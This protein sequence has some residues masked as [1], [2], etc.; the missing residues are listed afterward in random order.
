M[1]KVSENAPIRSCFTL[2][3]NAG[4]LHTLGGDIY[5]IHPALHAY[6]ERLHPASETL[7]RAFIDFMS[8]IAGQMVPQKI[9]EQRTCFILNS[10]TFYHALHLAKK[11]S[12]EQEAVKLIFS[13]A[14]YAHNSHDYLGAKQL[15]SSLATHYSR[16]NIESNVLHQLGIIAQ[17]Q[18]DFEAAKKLYKQSLEIK[19]KEGNENS[20]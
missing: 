9:H 8:E 10:S 2:L 17:E 14:S 12:M 15:Y 11:L 13:L 1:K 16:H 5:Q 20:H 7:Q 18:R 3:E 4:L 19:K 6:I